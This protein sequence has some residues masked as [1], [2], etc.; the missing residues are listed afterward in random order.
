MARQKINVL[1]LL[2]RNFIFLLKLKLESDKVRH[3]IAKYR[4]VNGFTFNLQTKMLYS[5]TSLNTLKG[6]YFPDV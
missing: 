2:F 1:K 4:Y 3:K 5:I 6:S